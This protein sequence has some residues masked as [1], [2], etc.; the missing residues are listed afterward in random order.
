MMK[1]L[2][3]N[4]IELHRGYDLPKN[5]RISG[6][7]PIVSSTGIVGKHNSYKVKGPGVITGRSGTI[8]KVIFEKG[9]FWPLNTT[10]FVSDFKG[11]DPKYV[12]Y[13]LQCFDLKH[14]TTGSTVPTL[15]RNDLSNLIIDV[16]TINEQRKRREILEILDAKIATNIEISQQLESMAK[17]I[18]DYWFLQFEF[19]DKDG[20][21]YKS[22]GGKMI[23]NKQ[24]KRKIPEGW[25]VKSIFECADVQYGKPLSTKLF[26]KNGIPVIRIR[27]IDTLSNSAYTQENIENK[28]LSKSGDLLIG[29]DGNFQMNFWPRNNDCVNQRIV[30]IRKGIIPLLLIKFQIKPYIDRKVSSV[31]R[32]T[33]GHLKDNDIKELKIL[34]PSTDQLDLTIFDTFLQ[35]IITIENESQQLKSLRNFLLPMLMNGQVSISD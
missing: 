29:M 18:Y 13:W 14:Y 5:K 16:P 27:D 15:N 32:S 10:L 31:A 20:K 28:Y 17:T 11:N 7:F 25:E 26:S 8:G 19:P 24:L 12:Y 30:R 33:V 3:R 4:F 35:K 9:C 6:D 1:T 22:N 2:F 23:W 34:L 21:P